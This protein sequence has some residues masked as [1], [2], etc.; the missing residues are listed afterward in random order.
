MSARKKQK[1]V[2][3]RPE[4]SMQSFLC[5]W[6]DSES[7]DL[8]NKHLLTQDIYDELKLHETGAPGK[9]TAKFLKWYT[10]KTQKKNWKFEL[11]ADRETIYCCIPG[12][13][14]KTAA[15]ATANGSNNPNKRKTGNESGK[16]LMLVPRDKVCS[17]LTAIHG[18][19]HQGLKKM[20]PK[21]R[22]RPFLW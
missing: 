21:V 6:H 17:I 13:T 20:T 19:D 10:Q 3:K 16:K 15:R 1:T 5:R 9:R 7:A 4:E 11:S 8:R 18:K 22:D 2:I 12:R 14:T